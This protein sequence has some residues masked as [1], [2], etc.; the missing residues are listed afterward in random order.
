MQYNARGW[1]SDSKDVV[2]AVKYYGATYVRSACRVM[3]VNIQTAGCAVR[4]TK[5][6]KL[7][8]K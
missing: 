5:T 7:R 8:N 6:E 1:A 2:D 4:C 3:K